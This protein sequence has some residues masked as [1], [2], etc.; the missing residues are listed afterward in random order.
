MYLL[1]TNI[2]PPS[3]SDLVEI[4]PFYDKYQ[5]LDGLAYCDK[6]IKSWLVV[7]RRF[8]LDREDQ[9]NMAWIARYIYDLPDFF[10]KSRSIAIKW[11]KD[12]LSRLKWSD[13]ELIKT[14]L[15]LIENDNETTKLMVSTYL[16]RK[17]VGMTMNEMRDLVKQPDFPEQCIFRNEQIRLLDE[18]RA[19]LRVK[20]LYLRFGGDIVDGE[21]RDHYQH[22]WADTHK[23]GAMRCVW[24]KE[25]N[26]Y[27]Y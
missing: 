8:Y 24:V 17:C 27:L 9:K 20:D 14:L 1:P 21:Y 23:C 4:L 3:T 16:G 19:Q 22:V 2:E 18:Q 11:G 25:K 7:D 12:W 6:I 5:F 26:R 10:P 15:P 13:A